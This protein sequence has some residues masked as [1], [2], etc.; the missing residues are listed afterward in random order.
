MENVSGLYGNQTLIKLWSH[1][2][3]ELDVC[4]RPLFANPITYTDKM[5]L[6]GGTV[7]RFIFM[8]KKFSCKN[9]FV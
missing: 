8:I 4:G 9:I 3:R 2:F 5:C 1:K 7:I 6:H